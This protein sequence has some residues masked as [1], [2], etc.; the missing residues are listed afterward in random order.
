MIIADTQKR[1]AW[2][3][4]TVPPDPARFRCYECRDQPVKAARIM[5]ELVAA[6]Y[7]IKAAASADESKEPQWEP[8]PK[9]RIAAVCCF[10]NPAG[11]KTLRKNYDRFA[12]QFEQDGW[13]PLYTVE[14]A[15]RGQRFTMPQSDRVKH[16]RA[17][18]KLWLK[19]NVLNIA[20]RDREFIPPEF[21]AIAW[22][23]CD[24]IFK[25]QNWRDQAEGLL[26]NKPVVQLYSEITHN[27]RDRNPI[28]TR[29]S[30]AAHLAKLDTLPVNFGDHPPGGAWAAHREF[31]DRFG[32]YEK[33]ITGGGDA[34]AHAAFMG[35]F[36][37][38]YLRAVNCDK[39]AD[40]FRR[41]ALPVARHVR[42]DVGCIKGR[43]T[44]LW[45]GDRENRQYRE[46]TQYLVDFDPSTD[47]H[48]NVT[49]GILEWAT[50][51]PELHRRHVEY[52]EQRRE[53]G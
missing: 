38:P 6:G 7:T 31:F 26:R 29:T 22:I 3:S 53:D 52:F 30:V 15:F 2:Q 40:D 14:I 36:E 13:P 18:D 43:I 48:R 21:D 28:Q 35:Q 8:M 42:G 41:W 19:E 44:H 10:Y 4:D 33:F 23:D 49:T 34:L 9:P 37:P 51:K 5:S 45:H 32:L 47:L 12:E 16:M 24:L 25:N 11:F 39:V 20:A 50:D 46:R 17:K 27:D 1:I